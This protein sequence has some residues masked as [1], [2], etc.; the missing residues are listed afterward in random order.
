MVVLSGDGDSWL[1]VVGRRSAAV[2]AA[3]ARS[4]RVLAATPTLTGSLRREVT[5][6]RADPATD[7]EIVDAVSERLTGDRVAAV[8]AATE[9]AV[10]P[11]ARLRSGLGVAGVD[12][13]VALACTDKAIMKRRVGAAG[14]AH[15]PFLAGGA[16]VSRARVV[17]E[18]GLP[19]V[20]KSRIGSGG[21]GT[22]VARRPEEVPDPLPA[23]RMAE[24]FLAGRELSVESLVVGGRV[25]WCNVTEYVEARG[26]N[27]LPCDT[28][29]AAALRRLNDGAVEA[30]G[31]ERGIA[32][33]EVFVTGSGLRFGELAIRPPGGHIMELISLAYG[34]SAWDAWIAAELG[35]EPSVQ[36]VAS[37]HAAVRV[38]HP[39]PGRVLE[40]AGVESARAMPGVEA[41][42]LRVEP[43]D[44]VAARLGAGQ[45]VGHLIVV[46]PD[47]QTTLARLAAASGSVRVRVEQESG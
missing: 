7:A 21:R 46:G 33:M 1:V 5:W 47:R 44:V 45:E 40:A 37:R 20:L 36:A 3:L 11:A 32:H 27:H 24:G 12:P 25:R 19:V 42:V 31:V 9:S 18:I 29:H 13:D 4:K 17:R 15:A 16:D 39:G 38:L 2:R 8:L 35:E 34:F 14:I 28:T 23:D 6:V 22:V 43:G 10:V 30:L 41:A 26:V